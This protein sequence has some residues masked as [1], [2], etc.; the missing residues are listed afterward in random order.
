MDT[1]KLLRV[2]WMAQVGVIFLMGIVTL[3]V[4]PER[5]DALVKILPYISGTTL[6]EGLAA[7]G[8]SSLKRVT[9]AT[10]EKAKTGGTK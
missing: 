2:A 6:F 4:F 10:L 1:K 5:V 3:F 8:G 9:E 7:A